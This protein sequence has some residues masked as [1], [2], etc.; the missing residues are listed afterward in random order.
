MGINVRMGK[1]GFKP[2]FDGYLLEILEF[3]GLLKIETKRMVFRC[4]MFL[5]KL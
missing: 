3:G 5:W 1:S 4:V 2:V